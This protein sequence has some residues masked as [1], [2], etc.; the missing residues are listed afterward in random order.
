M[1]SLLACTQAV[2]A[3][4]QPFLMNIP[5]YTVSFMRCVSRATEPFAGATISCTSMRENEMEGKTGAR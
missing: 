4:W 5:T 1:G 3:W 2:S